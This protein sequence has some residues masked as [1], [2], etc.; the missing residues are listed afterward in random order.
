M[1]TI[2]EFSS[3]V[4]RQAHDKIQALLKAQPTQPSESAPTPELPTAEMAEGSA[5]ETKTAEPQAVQEV[6]ETSEPQADMSSPTESES[7]G[8]QAPMDAK[9]SDDTSEK[10]SEA[11]S[12][13][14]DESAAISATQESAP[15][16]PL[17]SSP[18]STLEATPPEN[19]TSAKNT[20]SAKIV[21]KSKVERPTL[22]EESKK[23]LGESMKLDEAKVEL[24][25]HALDVAGKIPAG[26]RRIV[27]FNLEE[28]DAVPSGAKKI[29]NHHFLAELIPGL[30]INTP[31]NDRGFSQKPGRSKGGRSGRG[32]SDRGDRG[33]GPGSDRGDS[34]NRPG[35]GPAPGGFQD[36]GQSPSRGPR[37]MAARAFKPAQPVG[38]VVIKPLNGAPI[39][40]PAKPQS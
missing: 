21:V 2:T 28:K 35:R 30:P 7:V 11:P 22:S 17:S 25:L 29:E 8:A 24:L 33:R 32:Q 37:P 5:A 20:Q 12:N 18:E 6:I 27:V 3:I 15:S 23:A 38:D 14:A 9:P 40:L 39:V 16:A 10:T 19:V 4:L 34:R 31:K 36:P 1:K 26:L 13:A